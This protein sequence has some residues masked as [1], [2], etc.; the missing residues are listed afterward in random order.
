M[1]LTIAVL[2]WGAHKTLVNTLESYHQ[3]GLDRL[4][5]ER[6][7]FFQEISEKDKTIATNY[8]YESFGADTNIGI[9]EAYRALVERATSD[10]FLFLENDWMLI[11][12]PTMEI[13]EAESMLIS[14]DVDVI[15]LRHRKFP[16]DPLWTRQFNGREY[17]RPTHLLDC[18]HWQDKP[19]K[20]PEIWKDPDYTDSWYFARAGHANWTNNPTMFR[21][22]WLRTHIVPRLGTRD[23]EVDL[24]PWW[25]HQN[26]LVAQGDGLFKHLRIG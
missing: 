23:V 2:S 20:F 18:V 14:F 6:L 15:R 8:G 24:Q 5:D 17:D 25:E 26:F 19:D 21:T 22:D 4:G 16:G 3:W 13:L 7:I 12:A 1:T 10:L 9:A 11:A